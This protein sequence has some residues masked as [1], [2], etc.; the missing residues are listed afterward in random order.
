[1]LEVELAKSQY[2]DFRVIL[3]EGKVAL[4]KGHVLL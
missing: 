4:L 3:S 1:M 2:R